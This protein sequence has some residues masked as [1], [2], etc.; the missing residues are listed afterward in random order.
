MQTWL[1]EL[2]GDSRAYYTKPEG[3]DNGQGFGITEAARGALGHWVT[4]KDGEIASYQVITPSAWN[5][6]PRDSADQRGPV[7]EA[8]IGARVSD[9]GNPVEL[10]HIVRSYDPCLVCCVHSIDGRPG[11]TPYRIGA[12]GLV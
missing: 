11:A 6:S 8:L 1:T 5:F 7:E 4:I 3:L 9:P 10:G 12:P 2:S